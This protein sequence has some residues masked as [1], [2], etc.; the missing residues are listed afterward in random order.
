MAMFEV[1]IDVDTQ[2]TSEMEA[3]LDVLDRMLE[4]RRQS[5]YDSHCETCQSWVPAGALIC[6]RC[7]WPLGMIIT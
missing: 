2:T 7:H 5:A 1:T 4:R 3:R 6:W